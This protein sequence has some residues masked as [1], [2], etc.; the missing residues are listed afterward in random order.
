M[1]ENNHMRKI[2]FRGNLR[3]PFYKDDVKFYAVNGFFKSRAENFAQICK[4]TINDLT[5][6][7]TKHNSLNQITLL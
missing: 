2:L 7:M 3:K 6:H 5:E 4:E 1:G